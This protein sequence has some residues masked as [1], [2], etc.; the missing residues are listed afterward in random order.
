[1]RSAV[2]EGGLIAI[3]IPTRKLELMIED[4][5]SQQ[6]LAAQELH[7]PKITTGSLVRYAEQVTSANTGA[8]FRGVDAT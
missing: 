7:T 8:I 2:Q 6:C 4:A 1:M 3:D 5:V